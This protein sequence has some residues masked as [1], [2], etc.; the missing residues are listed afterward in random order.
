MKENINTGCGC[1]TWCAK[2]TLFDYATGR[3]DVGSKRGPD[4]I[5]TAAE[6]LLV[7]YMI[8][9][10][11]I[12]YGCTRE[13][14]CITCSEKYPRQRWPTKPFKND[15]PGR[16]WWSLFMKRHPSITLRSPEHLQL[17]QV[18]CCTPEA[19]DEWYAGFNQFLMTHG[20]RKL[21]S[22]YLE[23]G[24]PLRPNN[25]K[26]IAIRNSRSVYSITSDM[27]HQISTLCAANAAGDIPFN[28][29]VWGLLRLTRIKQQSQI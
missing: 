4:S 27:K 29:L 1:C 20:L 22:S 13:Q 19:L 9:M 17:S 2:C 23:C 15:K 11:E 8:H 26:V 18:R 5:L 12:G 16:K 28:L 14:I 25:G 21:G 7:D 24:F 6:K 10:A 3:V